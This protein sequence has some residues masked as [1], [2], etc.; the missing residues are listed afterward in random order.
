MSSTASAR[1][2]QIAPGAAFNNACTS[3]DADGSMRVFVQFR[4]SL[5]G[6]RRLLRDLVSRMSNHV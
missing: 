5:S 4:G 2:Q 6:I 1:S 3:F